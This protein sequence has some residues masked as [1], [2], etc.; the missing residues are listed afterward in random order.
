MTRFQNLAHF[1]A[2]A[3]AE[4]LTQWTLVYNYLDQ[5]LGDGNIFDFDAHNRL[6]FDDGFFS[7]SQRYFWAINTLQ[8]IIKMVRL[9][10]EAWE[11]CE[12]EI[13]K[14]RGLHGRKSKGRR[15]T[16]R[17]KG[18]LRCNESM[19]QLRDLE[20]EFTRQREKAIALRDGLFSASAVMESRASTKL[21]ETV[22]LLTYVSIFYLPLSFCTSIWS[23]SDTFG[24]RN[25]IIT[26]LA[27][28]FGTYFTVFNL[29]IIVSTAKHRYSGIRNR[30]ISGMCRDDRENFK[31]TGEIFQKYEAN[32]NK[33]D[34]KPSEWWIPAYLLSYP[35]RK[36][37]DYVVATKNR[38]LAIVKPKT[39]Q[40]DET[41]DLPA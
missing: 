40:T 11:T 1:A 39:Q 12:R 20:V 26:A 36:L 17:K 28:S 4:V 19:K 22:K 5:L 10:I 27:V 41:P 24:Y 7:R 6:M 14:A 38:V 23:T 32:V 8:E 35:V 25:L 15:E 29:N 37:G 34:S 13:S 16:G 31:E 21:G 2:F 30:I 33:Y 3:I 9:N 18:V